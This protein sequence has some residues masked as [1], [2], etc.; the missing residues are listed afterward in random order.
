M[1]KTGLPIDLILSK[2]AE[3][4]TKSQ[5]RAQKAPEVYLGSL[6]TDIAQTPYDVVFE[7]DR[8]KLK[9]YPPKAGAKK[10][11]KTATCKGVTNK[12]P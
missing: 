8:V 2:L 6:E 12:S 3:D 9:Y 7:E 10:L 1:E 5:V 4:A 11:V